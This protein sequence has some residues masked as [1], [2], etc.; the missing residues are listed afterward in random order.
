MG[1]P[2]L[3]MTTNQIPPPCEAATCMGMRR[4]RLSLWRSR[5]A[6]TASVVIFICLMQPT[7]TLAQD[8]SAAAEALFNDARTALAKKEFDVACE[9]FRESDRLD[10]AVGT[11]FNLANCEEQRGRLATAWAV[12]R[13]VLEQLPPDDPRVSIARERVARLEPRVPRLT[14]RARHQFNPGTTV[15]VADLVLQSASFG[16][17]V[18]LNPGTYKVSVV[19]PGTSVQEFTVKL[20]EGD[21]VELRIP[22]DGGVSAAAPPDGATSAHGTGVPDEAKFAKRDPTLAYV[23]GGVGAAGLAVGAIA[24]ILGLHDESVG[25][26]NCSDQTRT[27][28]QTGHDAN[29]SARSLAAVSTAGFVVGVLGAGLGTYLWLTL[30]DTHAAMVGVGNVAGGTGIQWRSQW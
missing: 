8:S 29:Q 16:S 28:S 30:P 4:G 18:P 25:N 10:P 7:V 26:G 12:F 20:A 17:P 19:A 15:R 22:A 13:E 3:I 5:S 23:V 24:G 2:P 11:R 1:C 14:L 27:C 6:R 9:K 21:S